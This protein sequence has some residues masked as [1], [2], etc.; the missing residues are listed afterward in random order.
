MLK[1]YRPVSNLKFI[2]KI[3]EK[4]VCAQ[5][6]EHLKNHDLFEKHQSAYRKNHNTETALLKIQNDLLLSADKKQISI[7]ALLDLSAAFDTIDHSILTLRLKNTFGFSDLVLDWF[8]SYLKDRTQSVKINDTESKPHPL[9]YGIPQG[10]ILGPIIYTLYTTPL[11]NIIKDHNLN[12]HMYADD[13]QLYLSI[14]PANVHDLVYSLECCL[15]DVKTWMVDNKL[16]LND[17]KT[18]VLLCNPKKYNVDL[19]TIKIGNDTVELTDSVKNLGVYFDNDL[20]MNAHL[21]NL[22]RAVYL[23]IR[24]LKHM[25][26]FLNETSLKTLAA[27][28]ILSK[29]DYCNSLFK[30]FNS[31]QIDKLQKLQNFAA[32][33]ICGKSLYD[34]VTPCLLQLHWLPIKFRV[35]FK[36]ALLVFKCLNGLAPPYLCDL[37][38]QYQPS[39]TLRSTSQLLLKIPKTKFK[40]LGD[41]SFS[42]SAPSV[43]NELPF[44]IRQIKSI[45]IFKTNLKTFYFRVAFDL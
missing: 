36:I 26:K 12:Y 41:K 34:H 9:L 8:I 35:N 15:N 14:E 30:K 28:F 38:E 5:I 17:E 42:H 31:T 1:N 27:S 20:S 45:S 24:R 23:E 22:Q 18:E 39:R 7:I 29:F 40:T 2:S 19:D 10:S 33:V 25:S 32:K 3:F 11:G 13:T 16:K 43:W 37:I 6:L 4:A 21:I 44:E